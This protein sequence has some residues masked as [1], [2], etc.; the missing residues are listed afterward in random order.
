MRQ[1]NNT[2]NFS[3]LEWGSRAVLYLLLLTIFSGSTFAENN[4]SVFKTANTYY[5]NKQFDEAEHFY[6]QVLQKD[7]NNVNAC[8]NLGNTYFHLK[9]YPEAILYYEKAA[10][11]QPDNKYIRQNLSITNN[12]LFSKIEFS[13]EF[14]VTRYS[15]NFFNNRSSNQWSHWML[16]T[17]WLAVICMC[18][19]FFYQLPFFRKSAGFS[20]LLAAFF[21]LATYSRYQQ[22]RSS[23]YA[24]V[25]SDK[26]PLQKTPVATSVAT[27][28][29]QAGMKVKLSDKDGGWIKIE[30]PNG[31]SGWI[32]NNSV[33]KI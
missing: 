10:K 3:P 8:Y 19:W 15:K 21:A 16:I 6:L 14:F 7:R 25:F 11:L 32:K 13:K 23:E 18:I 26:T 4:Q 22:E 29:I 2:Y 27:D 30:L 33:E 20:F 12:K 17:L 1:S 24:I 9:K 5:S 28:S 31:K